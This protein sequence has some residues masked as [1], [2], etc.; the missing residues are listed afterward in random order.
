MHDVRR[1][2]PQNLYFERICG[3][4]GVVFAIAVFGSGIVLVYQEYMTG[5]RFR[6]GGS[7]SLTRCFR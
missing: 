4:V 5:L 6:P 3:L 7:V 1:M 2:V